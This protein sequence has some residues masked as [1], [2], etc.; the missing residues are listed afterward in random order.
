MGPG[1]KLPTL[2]HITFRELRDSYYENAAGLLRGGADALITETCPDLLQAKA[3][4][5]GT[6]RAVAALAPNA[7]VIASLTIETTGTMLLGTEIGAAL[8]ALEPLGI[9]MIGLNCATGPGEMSEHLRYLAAH[10]RIPISC[11]P[12]AGLPMLTSDGAS[13]PLTPGQ[14]ADAHD[15]FARE[16]GLSLVGGCCG[17]TPEHIAVLAD[18]VAG[19]PVAARKPRPEPGV[20]SLYAHVP[21]R[22]DTAFLAIGE[23]TNANGSKAF[24]DAM[25]EGRLEDC[26]QIARDQTRDGAHLLDVCVDYVG[27]DGAADMRA[28]VSR[29][30]TAATLPL[31]L[32]STEPGVIEAGLGLTGGR[33]VVNSVN[34]EDG[35]GPDSRIA[36]VMPLVRE[37]GAAVIA[38]TIDEQGQARTAEW[39]VAVAERLIAD[40]TGNWGMRVEDII[41]DCL[42]FPI[43][44]GQEEA[45]RDAIETMEGMAQLRGRPP[46]G[47]T[48]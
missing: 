16:F 46:T 45:R 12:N 23:R 2:G 47:K 17:T 39:K 21:F 18:R 8:T 38:L 31:V 27:R 13:Y 44:T 25:L 33:S 6:K 4:I 24:R 28:V 40:L 26:V 36:R 37:H 19:R 35:D 3:A 29:L 43:A 42:T 9:D 34:Y 1:T 30:A 32:D 20:A 15:R 10:A 11:E 48:P 7:L 41:V 22:Q 14:L 5:I